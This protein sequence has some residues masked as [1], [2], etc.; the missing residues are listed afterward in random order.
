M[1]TPLPPAGTD[2]PSALPAEGA[3]TTANPTARTS[4]TPSTTANPTANPAVAPSTTA[5]PTART[6][7]TP[8]T[9]G[10]PTARSTVAP[11]STP[12]PVANN[13]LNSG[14]ALRTGGD[15]VNLD[16]CQ[17]L[18]NVDFDYS[19]ASSGSYIGRNKNQFNQY[20][21]VL[22]ND[23]VGDVENLSL[24]SEQFDN[25]AWVKDEV[26]VLANSIAAP[27]KTK[28]AD[29][30]IDNTANRVHTLTLSN[31]TVVSGS[32][33]NLSVYAKAG[34]LNKIGV[35]D[36]DSADGYMFDL[37]NGTILSSIGTPTNGFIEYVGDGWYRCSIS[38][39]AAS[40]ALKF[41]FYL[42]TFSAYVGTGK[43]LYLHGAQA[44][45]GIKPLPYVKTLA[46]AVTQ[47]FT[48]SPRIE[49]DAATGDCLGYLAEGASTNLFTDSEEI[50]GWNPNGSPTITE[51]S[52]LA[53]D[54]TFSADRFVTTGATSGV[55]KAAATVIGSTYTASVYLK[56]NNPETVQIKLNGAT[57]E[58]RFNTITGLVTSIGAS[59]LNANIKYI[60]N[61]WFRC[62]ISFIAI[63]TSSTIVLYGSTAA[64]YLIW[65]AQF[66]ALPFATSYIRTEGSAV[67]RA[68][69]SLD[70]PIGL[71]PNFNS[72]FSITSVASL[73]GNFAVSSGNNQQLYNIEGVTSRYLRLM[74]NGTGEARLREGVNSV[75]YN[76]EV[77][78]LA[79]KRYTNSS[80]LASF[81]LYVDNISQGTAVKLP[82]SG[83][84]TTFSMAGSLY[85]NVKSF[86]VYNYALT[87]DEVKAL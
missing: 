81:E 37:L 42:D 5:T 68:A 27:D 82:P 8:A 61:G 31:Q 18:Y 26:T 51:N 87:A 74:D 34:N 64:D 73:I 32:I 39:I 57:A 47:S 36:V 77:G 48:A 11:S 71:L 75:S 41:R 16:F 46:T 63:A 70:L 29:K 30:I 4:V 13:P 50:G 17:Q 85:G 53:L 79:A 59:T 86:R 84:A 49:Y 66:E 14:A 43:F 56:N 7:L 19:R 80:G 58:A 9:T 83:T 78:G 2:A 67:T 69:D 1:S 24:Y 22:K 15:V 60:S 40:T 62:S 76:V 12:L 54:G 3:G 72:K 44:T 33:Y 28:T 35:Y 6:S 21:Y 10:L 55:F 25:A 23:F 52:G 45:L 20:D 65:G 38:I